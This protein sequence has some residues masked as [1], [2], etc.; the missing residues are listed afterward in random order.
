MNMEQWWNDIDRENRRTRRKTYPSATLSTTNPTWLDPGANPGRRG[1]R[2]ATNDLSHGTAYIKPKICGY[3][4]L[5]LC[6]NFSPYTVLF[7]SRM[8]LR[9]D[10]YHNT[11]ISMSSSYDARFSSYFLF[12][13]SLFLSIT[14]L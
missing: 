14:S 8:Y 4:C 1:E 7:Y 11:S 5:S 9:A 3:M 10:L 2:P 12:T 13:W 6:Y